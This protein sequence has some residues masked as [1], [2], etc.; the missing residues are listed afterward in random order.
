MT[1]NSNPQKKPLK[2]LSPNNQ[3]LLNGYQ[4]LFTSSSKAGQ[5]REIQIFSPNQS[6]KWDSISSYFS[7]SFPMTTASYRSFSFFIIKVFFTRAVFEWSPFCIMWVV[8]IHFH[9]YWP[10]WLLF[11]FF[12]RQ[13]KKPKASHMQYTSVTTW[14]LWALSCVWDEKDST[15]KGHK[16]KFVVIVDF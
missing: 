3:D 1:K 7:S 16:M 12:L 10:P 11:F 14:E 8:F 9:M 4:F 2:Q 5:T 6:H 15:F 13:N